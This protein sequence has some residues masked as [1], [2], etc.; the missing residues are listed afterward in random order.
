M[1]R[2]Q[3]GE[4]SAGSPGRKRQ[5]F[6]AQVNQ[7]GSDDEESEWYA[8][9][10]SNLRPFAPEAVDLRSVR[11]PVCKPKIFRHSTLQES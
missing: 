8:R 3:R 7:R 4:T 10:D 2:H 9:Q 6:R 11:F 5:P 1:V